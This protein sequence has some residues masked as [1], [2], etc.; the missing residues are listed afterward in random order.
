MVNDKFTRR[1]NHIEKRMHEL[2]L[3]LKF[4]HMEY[5]EKYWAEAKKIEK[6]NAKA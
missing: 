1:F 2:G 4:D 3:E 5:M 6:E